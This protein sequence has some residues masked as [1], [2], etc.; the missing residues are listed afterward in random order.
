MQKGLV[1]GLGWQS[2]SVVFP[3]IFVHVTLSSPQ[4]VNYFVYYLCVVTLSAT[5]EELMVRTVS[6][7]VS[8][9]IKAHESGQDLNINKSVSDVTLSSYD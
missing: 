8:Q 2:D 3:A 9:L 1:L 4:Y 7:I 6:E 5:K